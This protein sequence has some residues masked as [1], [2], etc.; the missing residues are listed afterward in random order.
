MLVVVTASALTFI[1]LFCQNRKQLRNVEK[2]LQPADLNDDEELKHQN[3][4]HVKMAFVPFNAEWITT[5]KQPVVKES[6]KSETKIHLYYHLC[7]LKHWKR[8]VRSMFAH[9]QQNS[10][11]S[12]TISNIYIGVVGWFFAG[13]KQLLQILQDLNIPSSKIE[14]ICREESMTEYERPT[15]RKLRDNARILRDRNEAHE[16]RCLYM[17]SKGVS[18]DD[19]N[20]IRAINSWTDTMMYYLIDQFHVCLQVLEQHDVCG[21]MFRYAPEPHFSGNFWI[22]RC[23]YLPKIPK[24]IGSEYLDP[25]MYILRH[26]N[27][28]VCSLWPHNGG[29]ANVSAQ[30]I[31][32]NKFFLQSNREISF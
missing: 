25:E 10:H 30:N 3:M 7:M 13:E 5:T 6:R 1:I 18:H 14:I 15:L 20:T 26:K 21:T 17:H 9:I 23:D 11:F 12:N 31:Y 22:C 29:Y 27:V 4:S 8:V 28:R 24:I 16:I 32:R 19:P 2:R